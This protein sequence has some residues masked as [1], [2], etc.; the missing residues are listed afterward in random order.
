MIDDKSISFSD[1]DKNYEFTLS[2]TEREQISPRLGG[3]LKKIN[4]QIK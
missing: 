2:R 1:N 4:N 3:Y